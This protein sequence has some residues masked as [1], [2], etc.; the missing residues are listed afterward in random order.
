MSGLDARG[1]LVLGDGIVPGRLVA[2]GGR[3]VSIEPDP[4]AADG[5]YVV[6]SQ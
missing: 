3:I 6:P 4:A 5:P 1:R 2:S